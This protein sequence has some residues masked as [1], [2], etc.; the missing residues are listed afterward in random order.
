MVGDRW[1]DIVA[2]QAAGCRTL[3][4]DVPYS[5]RQRCAPNYVVADV[6][7]AARLIVQLV[8]SG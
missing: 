2:G 4:L 8:R 6:L 7:E 5:Q 3:L 1:S